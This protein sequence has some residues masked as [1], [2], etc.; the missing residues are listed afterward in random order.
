MNLEPCGRRRTS[1]G[2]CGGARGRGGAGTFPTED[3]AHAKAQR[4]EG[5]WPSEDP[6]GR[7]SEQTL[8]PSAAGA[9]GTSGER[10]WPRE[11]REQGSVD[12]P[13]PLGFGR[14]LVALATEP[15]TSQ[16]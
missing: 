11:L 12:V 1:L 9:Q 10:P 2:L 16:A 5:A 7:V 6:E 3:S 15:S 4:Q 8:G 13:D 14:P